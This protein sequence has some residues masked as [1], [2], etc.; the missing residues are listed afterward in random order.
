MANSHMH[1]GRGQVRHPETDGRL[2]E[3]RGTTRGMSREDVT[4]GGQGRVKNPATDGR[5]KQNR[6][7]H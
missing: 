6:Q 7:R 1:S 3:N 2:R 4:P 5:L